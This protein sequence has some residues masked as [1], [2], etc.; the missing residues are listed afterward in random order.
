MKTR[1]LLSILIALGFAA[2]LLGSC[3]LALGPRSEGTIVLNLGGG[4]SSRAFSDAPFDG[5]P[6]F[7]SFT[8]T[9]SG[10]GMPTASQ[11]VPG[12]TTSVTL[13]VPAG[14]AR[15]VEVYAVVD[16]A[17]TPQTPQPTLAKAY[18]GTAIVDVAGGQTIP[19]AMD[20]AVVETKIVL[21]G[22]WGTSFADSLDGPT[23]S[24]ESSPSIDQN[25][26]IEFDRYGRLFVSNWD[27]IDIYTSL[28]FGADYSNTAS[29]NARMAYDSG[30]Q[31]MYFLYSGEGVELRYLDLEGDY[32]SY[33]GNDPDL[34]LYG[35][36]I[37]VDEDGYVYVPGNY[38]LPSENWID[39]VAKL[40]IDFNGET[41]EARVVGYGTYD[42]LGLGYWVTSGETYFVSL[43][44]ADM[45]F[46][47]GVLYIAAGE[48]D[49]EYS[50][51]TMHHGKVVAVR[52]SDMTKFREIGWSGETP[53][54]SPST[55][56]Y[57]PKRFLAIAPRRLFLADEGYDGTSEIDRV[58]ELDLE[59]W[60]VAGVGLEGT[61]NFF[62]TYAC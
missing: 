10:S 46:Q 35:T 62:S 27:G 2:L 37:A 59:N 55:Q 51:G 53:I 24:A 12:T 11:T 7:S 34:V 21:P 9:V 43:E 40:R 26:D 16:W 18:G 56:F 22:T 36:G 19:V 47:D 25:S 38:M 49:G 52:T 14:P 32:E 4:P 58:V 15:K 23:S 30:N 31:R 48:H 33:V 44:I 54:P 28:D 29:G 50:Y 60:S 3:E 8:V 13:Q 41:Y 17:S 20:M 39:V 45:R 6:V 57:G 61:V 1:K 5:L 42:S